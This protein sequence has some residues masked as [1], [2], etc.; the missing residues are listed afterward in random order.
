MNRNLSRSAPGVDWDGNELDISIGVDGLPSLINWC[1]SASGR[2]V[3]A[4]AQGSSLGGLELREEQG[5]L[6]VRIDGSTATILG[7]N[8][9]FALLA[10]N[11]TRLLS[12][13]EGGALKHVH[14]EPS[15]D[16]L[17]MDPTSEALIVSHQNAGSKKDLSK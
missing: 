15:T 12:D 5:R 9:S 10:R 8:D 16:S 7:S 1:K 14:F 2:V 3:L 17:L 6:L 13:W 4:S 11:L